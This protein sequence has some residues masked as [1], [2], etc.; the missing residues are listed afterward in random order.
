MA[1]NNSILLVLSR[2]WQRRC[3]RC[4]EGALFR[5][6]LEVNERCSSCDLVYQPDHGDTLM[7]M[8]ITDRIPI[9][10]GFIAVYFAGFR[11]SSG[12][13]TAGFLIALLAPVIATLRQR[14][15]LALA[16]V[17]LSQVYLGDRRDSELA[18]R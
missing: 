18:L 4:G 14:Q 11:S 2:G 15:G 3:P 1:R 8:M 7:F 16:L 17:Y 6:R 13:V 10:L 12:P 5:R 9:F